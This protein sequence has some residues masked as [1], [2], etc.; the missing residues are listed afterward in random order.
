MT[1]TATGKACP[2][3]PDECFNANGADPGRWGSYKYAG[4]ADAPHIAL[5]GALPEQALVVGREKTFT[6]DRAGF[7]LLFVNDTDE[8]NNQGG[9]QVHV[10]VRPP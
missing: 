1:V 6:V 3:G 8:G 7:L 5:V 2:S 10:E 4:F 9:F